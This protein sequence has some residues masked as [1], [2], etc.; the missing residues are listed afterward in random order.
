VNPARLAAR[1]GTPAYV[2]DLARIRAAHTDLRAALPEPSSLYYSLKANPHPRLI[3]ELAGAG[4]LAEA[5]SPGEV[6]AALAAGLAPGDVLLTGPGKSEAVVRHALRRGVTRYSVDSPVDLRRVGALAAEHGVAA[7]C[8]LRVNADEPVPGMGLAMT[9]TASQFG[10]DASWVLR[11]PYLFRGHAGARVVGLHLFMGTNLLDE[12]TLL[13]QFEV[14]TAL[15]ATLGPRLGALQEVDLGGGFGTPFARAGRRP[16]FRTLA[17]RLSRLLDDRLPGWRRGEPRISFES[18]RY[19]TGSSGTL[20]AQVVDVKRSKGEL[21]VILDTGVHHLGGMS[22]LRRLPP[23]S[24]QL[25]PVETRPGE[26]VEWT[27]VGPLC[28][29]LDA[30]NRNLSLPEPLVGDLVTVPNVG[31]YGLTASLIDF[32]GHLPP[33]EVFHDGGRVVA[34]SR[35]Q[36]A[37]LPQPE[38]LPR[39]A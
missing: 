31:A 9:G 36:S 34:A 22:G 3:E 30:L 13:A 7:R 25:E 15:A 14:G 5:S 17:A 6:D 1:F 10:A 21:F 24:V 29:P 20:L 39:P 33:V 2:Y 12:D 38:L 4:C 23:A 32:L 27:A 28:T 11:E 37:H 26:P 18:G 8:L 35:R 19:L 16:V